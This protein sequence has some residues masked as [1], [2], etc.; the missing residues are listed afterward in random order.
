M[1]YSNDRSETRTVNGNVTFACNATGI[2]PPVITWKRGSKVV[3]E[4]T[5][6]AIT[7]SGLTITNLKEND[8]GEYTCVANNSVGMKEQKSKL[9]VLGMIL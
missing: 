6:Y 9:T 2:P 4:D 5:R 7:T 3:K 8:A 1:F